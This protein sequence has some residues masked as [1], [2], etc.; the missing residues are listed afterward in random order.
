MK[1]RVNQGVVQDQPR[2]VSIQDG[3]EV[4]LYIDGFTQSLEVEGQDRTLKVFFHLTT[5][6][7]G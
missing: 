4:D 7:L 6:N 3:I 5:G 1:S 2:A